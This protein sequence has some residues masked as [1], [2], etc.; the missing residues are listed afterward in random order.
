MNMNWELTK[1]RNGCKTIE[2]EG[3]KIGDCIL[4]EGEDKEAQGHI[5]TD[6]YTADNYEHAIVQ[7]KPEWTPICNESMFKFGKLKFSHKYPTAKK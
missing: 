3:L 1:E 5:I 4:F 6:I 2:V 7:Y